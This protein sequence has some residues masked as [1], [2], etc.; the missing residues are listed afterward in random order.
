[1]DLTDPD[2]GLSHFNAVPARLSKS[3]SHSHF[4]LA[5]LAASSDARSGRI[6]MDRRELAFTLRELEFNGAENPVAIELGLTRPDV[7]FGPRDAALL[8]SLFP[9]W[10]RALGIGHQLSHLEEYRSNLDDALDALKIGVMVLGPRG[11][12]KSANRHARQFF[13]E[14]T[15]LS[16]QEGRLVLSDPR[17]TEALI[18]KI[19]AAAFGADS[20]PSPTVIEIEDADP[21]LLWLE[22][23]RPGFALAIVADGA[24]CRPIAPEVLREAFAL[25]P[26][27]AVVASLFSGGASPAKIAR[28]LQVSPQTVARK[29]AK[30]RDRTQVENGVELMRLIMASVPATVATEQ[31]VA[32]L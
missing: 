11:Q 13:H 32:A 12:L 21:A 9:H 31:G 14:G 26:T 23:F 29:L 24:G 3:F 10:H 22:S 25:T 16:L 5:Y 19:K 28:N 17:E 6:V 1:V 20:N 27:E 2:P 8:R 4:G 30:I 18:G 15:S 7:G